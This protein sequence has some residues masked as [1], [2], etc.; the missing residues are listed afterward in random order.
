MSK[1]TILRI[2]IAFWSLALLWVL[3]VWAFDNWESMSFHWSFGSHS[4]RIHFESVGRDVYCSYISEPSGLIE[5]AFDSTYYS[6]QSIMHDSAP[7]N[8][9]EGHFLDNWYA[10]ASFVDSYALKRHYKRVPHYTVF[11]VTVPFWQICTVVALLLA[12]SVVSL[13][14][15]GR[16][17][18]GHCQSCGYDLRGTPERCPECG[19]EAKKAVAA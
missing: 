2:S 3:A 11:Y 17:P 13:R 7:R 19:R 16:R 18:A 5:Q 15:A 12:W 6:P 8:I 9:K 1:R 4:R 10:Y 14:C